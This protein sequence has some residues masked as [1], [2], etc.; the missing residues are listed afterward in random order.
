MKG[1]FKG[2]TDPVTKLRNGTGTY[3][4]TNNYFQ[5]QGEWVNGRKHGE[6]VLLMKDGSSFVGTFCNGEITGQGTKT[7]EDGMTYSG[8]W[9]TGERN[10]YGECVYGLRNRTEAYFKGEWVNNV[11][12]GPG[13]LGLKNGNV[14]KA[15]WDCNKP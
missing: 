2:D 4:Y 1:R 13:E 7:Y 3:T 11:R 5:Y 9:Q 12:H 8:L 10:G 14:I 6:G 15:V